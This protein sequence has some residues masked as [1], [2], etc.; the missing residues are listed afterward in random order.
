MAAAGLWTTPAD[1]ARA[2]LAV[3]Q[4]PSSGSNGFLSAGAISQMLAP[5]VEEHMGIGFF[6]K[7]KGDTLRF[8]HGGWDE[9]FVADMVAYQSQGKGAV[10][11]VNSNQGY[12]LMFEIQRA[13]AQTYEWPDYFTAKKAAVDVSAE[14]LT[15]YVGAYATKSDLRF[16]VTQ[17]GE[18][19][20]LQAADQPPIALQPESETKFFV[21]F[22]NSAVSFEK[23]ETGEVTKLILH[24]GEKQLSAEKQK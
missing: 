16:K 8:G 22:L 4:A 7:G 14:R 19:L 9:G 13:I 2:A 5:Q 20:C 18:T 24:Q 11:M 21:A 1:L 23:A 15:S 3:Q 10:I 12:D 17:E 6:L